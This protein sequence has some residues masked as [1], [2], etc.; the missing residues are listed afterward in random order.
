LK[1]VMNAT[2]TTLSDVLWRWQRGITRAMLLIGVLAGMTL[3]A[4]AHAQI[5]YRAA[6]QAN[7]SGGQPA[8][9]FQAAGA[10]VSGTGNVTP[11]WPAH[12]I[13]DV[14]LLFIESA[15]GEAA[16]LS[17]P[18]GFVAVTNSPQA[19]GAGTAGTRISVYWA[20]ATS[21]A[22]PAPTVLDP[23][24]HVYAQILTYRG[25]VNTGN[26]WDVTG[27]GVKAAAS[28]TVT[29]TG[30]T[31]TVPNTRVVQAV[32][33]D[34]DSAAAAFS[35]QTNVNLTGIAERSDAGTTAGNGGGIGIWDGLNA[36]AGAT[37]NTTA[38]VTSSINAFL[39]VALR[40]LDSVLTI[41]VPAGTVANDV[42]IASITYRPC[43][44]VSGAA[45][46]TTITPPA[47]A[48]TWTL[49]NTV[50]DQTTGG[51]TGGFG[52]R[53]FVYRRVATV[54]EP[55]SYTWTFSGQ[56]VHAG[57]SGGI[58]SLSGVDTAS[59]IVA[60]A[61]SLTASGTSH[62]APS[63]PL[64]GVAGA[65]LVTTHS[66]NSSATWTAPTVPTV[67]TSRV[68]IASLA[69]PNDLGL[70]VQMNTLANAPDPTVART[71]G[72]TSPPAADTGV[73]HALAL[74]PA[75]V[76]VPTPGA[77]NAF[78]TSTAPGAITGVIRTKVAG[79]AFSLDVVAISG[80]VQQAGFTD[81]V[82][83]EL[84][85]NNTL[86]IS[87]DAQNCPTSSTLVQTVL[88]NPTIAG[89][90]S[91]VN[92]A[93]VANSWRDVRVRVRWPTASPTVTWCSTDNFAIRPNTLASFAVTDNDW[94]TA[95]T[96][97]ALTDTIFGAVTHKA[98]RPLS[99]RA[100]AVNAAAATTTNYVGAPTSTLTACAGAACTATFGTM[101]LATT[102]VAGQ[103]VSDVASYNNVGSFALQLV[104]S[105]FASVDGGDGTP[106]DCSAS[107]HYVCSATINVGRFVP[108]HF[109][110]A[111][112]APTFGTACGAGG[113]TYI[114]EA[115]NYT[116]AP[117]I[118]VT[119]QDFANNTTTL[120]N[121]I[122]SWWRIT[123]ASLTGKS[124]TAAAGTL[125]ASG[126][127][128]IDP[129][130]VSVGL[131]A[132][133]LTFSSGTGLFFTRTTPVAPFDAD[134][135]LAINVIDAD[136]VT[137]A[138]NPARFGTATAGNGI[139]F[140]SG[141]PMRFGR[142]VV[143]NANGSQLV[144]LPVQVEAQYWSGAP[145]NAFI[146]NTQDSCTSI[147]AAN[148]AMANYTG[149]LSGSPACETAIS[150]GGT[151]SAGRRTLQLAA[152]GSGN[153][154]SVDL[155]VNLGA[156]ASGNTCTTLGGAP[157]S[158]TTANLPHLQ[159]NW[160]GGAYDQN[161]TARA[162]FGVFR[163]AEEIIF[164]RENF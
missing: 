63:V 16:T 123:N 49:V 124:Y 150:G 68:N 120:Y 11:A 33:R 153:N 156:A 164:V 163:G 31:T 23:G 1:A 89:G 131:G 142:L 65:W 73:T 155:T 5:A 103:L 118:T 109:A 101:T 116:A 38:N 119:A 78:E 106:A 141:K 138:T 160:T 117:V 13:G 22:M 85:G 107:G 27:G 147:A 81:T 76:G 60:E 128:G 67:M 51:G 37:G 14:A 99:V 53:L 154:G 98:G 25:V 54:A 55:A 69:V 56:L 111:L 46:T 7:S 20:R 145:M 29:V 4:P 129:V 64:G 149:N 57:A 21:T 42:M 158:A 148:E 36:T 86:G 125:D 26:P 75:V 143:R 43:S 83:V 92:F 77:L 15:G 12:A 52:N 50:T 30:V 114:G 24:N 146:T 10:A 121:T 2:R 58:I 87:L 74:R 9:A 105:A 122:G 59:P 100:T 144:A 19:T 45:C 40:P 130:I 139:A 90:R 34:N 97:R 88:P 94:Q 62:A 134:I 41:P 72:W 135:S 8:P 112:N 3:G 93:A 32:S 115:F 133:T 137:L 6:S 18:A 96:G 70:A 104:D 162:T 71:A 110:V 44:N 82:I 79:S 47:P 136:G 61:G 91:T 39:T 84:L 80:G 126:V 127:P 48:G 159:G 17:V 108:D 157:A 152:P 102:F 28:T 140:G 132:G 113:F 35:A 95:G 66:A 161:P 151:L